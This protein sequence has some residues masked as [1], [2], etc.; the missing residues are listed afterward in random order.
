MLNRYFP[1]LQWSQILCKIEKKND[2][3]LP[4]WNSLLQWCYINSAVN[5]TGVNLASI[6]VPP[7]VNERSRVKFFHKLLLFQSIRNLF[8]PFI[9]QLYFV[10]DL[11]CCF[12]CGQSALLYIPLISNKKYLY[13]Y[14][15]C[16]SIELR[17]NK[18]SKIYVLQS[19]RREVVLFHFKM[20][21][22]IEYEFSTIWKPGKIFLRWVMAAHAICIY[23]LAA[24]SSFARVVYLMKTLLI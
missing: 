12:I 4:S 20:F 8:S 14:L 10:N 1:L 2:I 18:K 23:I 16:S 19:C 3:F 21:V 5:V 6:I 7:C 15:A 9:T 17:L 22:H 24:R 11:L 13:F